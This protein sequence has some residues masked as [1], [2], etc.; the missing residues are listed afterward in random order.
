MRNELQGPYLD[1]KLASHFRFVGAGPRYRCEPE[2]AAGDGI[3]DIV[4]VQPIAGVGLVAAIALHRVRVRH[5][6]QRKLQ[7]HALDLFI[8]VPP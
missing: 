4:Q 6:W 3:T 5:A 1:A 2:G 7:L 8:P